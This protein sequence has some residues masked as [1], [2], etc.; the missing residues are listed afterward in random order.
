MPDIEEQMAMTSSSDS[1]V[2]PIRRSRCI[3]ESST[4]ESSSTSVTRRSICTADT[5]TTESSSSSLA[6][7]CCAF[8]LS[9]CCLHFSRQLVYIFA[10][11]LP[12][13]KLWASLSVSFFGQQ[14]AHTAEHQTLL[15]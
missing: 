11:L 8:S 12:F 15:K 5:L 3:I 2:M 6:V 10:G 13:L 4:S 9:N 1:S 7:T 14:K